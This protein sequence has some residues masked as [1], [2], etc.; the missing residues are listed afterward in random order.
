MLA[1]YGCPTA[2]SW[3]H[4]SKKRTWGATL[5]QRTH[6]ETGDNVTRFMAS[7][8]P[9]YTLV[10]SRSRTKVW[11]YCDV[12]V[13]TAMHNKRAMGHALTRTGALR[14]V[15]AH[16]TPDLT[17][18]CARG[19]RP[20]TRPQARLAFLA[21]LSTGTPI[22]TKPSFREMT[23]KLFSARRMFYSS[24]QRARGCYVPGKAFLPYLALPH[25][26]H[27]RARV[28]YAVKYLTSDEKF[29]RACA[30]GDTT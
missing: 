20:S 19:Q 25:P 27:P 3:P 11:A 24:R 14:I 10:V 29:P 16:H 17:R 30:R 12:A 21:I 4:D 22:Y 5:C 1:T 15:G 9:S 2:R 7:A 13:I 18:A 8:R 23:V 6:A 26:S 28:C